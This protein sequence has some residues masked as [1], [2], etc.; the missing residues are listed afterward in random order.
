MD[1]RVWT[2]HFS[3]GQDWQPWAALQ[4]D[5]RVVATKRCQNQGACMKLSTRG[6]IK[7]LR[8]CQTARNEANGTHGSTI[9]STLHSPAVALLPH[10][11]AAR[12]GTRRRRFGVPQC[13][14]GCVLPRSRNRQGVA[15]A[16]HERPP[17][18]ALAVGGPSK[19]PYD[20]QQH[21]LP[22]NSTA[23]GAAAAFIASSPDAHSPRRVGSCIAATHV[24]GAGR[25]PWAHV[26]QY[27]ATPAAG[28]APGPQLRSSWP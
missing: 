15:P 23:V 21:M 12:Q 25:M 17:S 3:S 1:N 4:P 19:A 16:V 18:H 9:C 27:T 5:V 10:S 7:R 13:G 14:G 22:P 2:H 26:A 28:V 11:V 6:V 8:Q 24:A 20:K